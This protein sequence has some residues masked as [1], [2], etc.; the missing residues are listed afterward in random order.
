MKPSGFA[1]SEDT[2]RRLDGRGRGRDLVLGPLLGIGEEAEKRVVH[3]AERRDLA[4][5]DVGARRPRPRRD[6]RV[7]DGCEPRETRGSRL[8]QQPE[9]GPQVLGRG[10][11]ED[12][13]LALPLRPGDLLDAGDQVAEEVL[14]K[15]AR[16]PAAASTC[17][18]AK[19]NRRKKATTPSSEYSGTAPS[20]VTPGAK[21]HEI[22][23][24]AR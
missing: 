18:R 20:I 4:R 21:V 19:G 3:P 12:V 22:V 16:L 2:E 15:P 14:E 7:G 11:H 10:G 5:M 17:S 6:L 23:E 13:R 9:P 24:R 1:A 8:V